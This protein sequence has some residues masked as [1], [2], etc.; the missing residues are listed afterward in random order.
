MKKGFTPTPKNFGVTLRSKGGFT[1]IE[2]LVSLG[3]FIIVTTMVVTNFRGGSRSDELKIAA[4]T[5]A[6]NLRR[7]QNMAL[8]GE[9]FEGITPA[10]GYG[11]YFNLGNP[12]KYIIFA[13]KNGNLAYDAG[14][15]LPDGLITLPPNMVIVGVLP[16]ASSAVVFKPPKPTV[17]INGGTVNDI[18]AVTVKHNL[19]GKSK[20]IVLNRISGRI[21]V[22]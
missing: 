7:A 10:G 2:L 8:A 3:I 15:V 9:Q 16:A 22:E 19:S 20:K 18:I 11:I 12:D 14:E 4:E 13:D 17:Y 6:S 5:V 21:D 1:I